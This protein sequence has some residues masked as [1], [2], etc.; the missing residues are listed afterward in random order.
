M[1]QKRMRSSQCNKYINCRNEADCG[2]EYSKYKSIKTKYRKV[3]L[4]KKNVNNAEQLSLAFLFVSPGTV[5]NSV[6]Q[7][8]RV[9]IK[10]IY[11]AFKRF[12]QSSIF[13]VLRFKL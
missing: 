11:Q 3:N 9:H 12:A 13:T 5:L 2:L 7:S 10:R 1:R 8:S 4:Y 6:K